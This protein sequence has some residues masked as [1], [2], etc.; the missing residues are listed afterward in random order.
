MS[1]YQ[2]NR[3]K[4]CGF[5]PASSELILETT[6][7]HPSG[8]RNRIAVYM[9]LMMLVVADLIEPV[10]ALEGLRPGTT[11]LE[12]ETKIE[13]FHERY[14]GKAVTDF[15]QLAESE[16]RFVTAVSTW[17]PA[18]RKSGGQWVLREFF[19]GADADLVIA[20][21]THWDDAT[22]PAYMTF[23]EDPSVADAPE[24]IAKVDAVRQI[25]AALTFACLLVEGTAAPVGWAKRR[26]R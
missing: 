8:V 2:A 3:G 10:A 1:T 12:A 4:L 6:P 24:N 13:A 14:K 26:E 9:G 15:Y 19:V 25:L 22:A 20:Q 5:H 7:G 11:R 21:N 23:C 18:R 16:S 17:M